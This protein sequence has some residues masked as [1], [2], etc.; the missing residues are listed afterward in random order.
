M[1]ETELLAL[2]RL[3]DRL[4][5]SSRSEALRLILAKSDLDTFTSEDATRLKPGAA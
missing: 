1:F 5:L 3:K 4:N 2:D